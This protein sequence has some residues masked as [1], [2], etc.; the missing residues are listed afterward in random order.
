MRS[1]WREIP[2]TVDEVK[3]LIKKDKHKSNTGV[4]LAVVG[5]VA[6]LVGIVIWIAKKREKDLEEHY[7]FFD[8]DF[9]DLDEN[10]DEFDETIYDDD[11]ENEESHYVQ[12]KDFM[13]KDE[14]K[15][16]DTEDEN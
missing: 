16:T 14:A 12:I 13:N 2:L 3:E 7:E 4:I 6:A 15:E 5:V 10:Y 9:D 11:D 8:E 1:A